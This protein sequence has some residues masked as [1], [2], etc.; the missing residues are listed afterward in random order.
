MPSSRVSVEGLDRDRLHFVVDVMVQ[1]DSDDQPIWTAVQ[2]WALPNPYF[3]GRDRT[4]FIDQAIATH[5]WT[6]IRG[7]RPPIK[8]GRVV[9]NVGP[10]DWN[11]IL[12]EAARAAEH[13]RRVE[14]AW[15]QLIAQSSLPP[16]DVGQIAGI[17]RPL[18]APPAA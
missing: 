12:T 6:V 13:Y 16:I 17:S 10:A 18:Q 8:N 5:G 14:V 2:S 3:T 4:L 7:R 1:L 15:Q 11:H 9:L